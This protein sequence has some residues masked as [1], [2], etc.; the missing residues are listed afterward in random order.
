MGIVLISSQLRMA[1]DNKMTAGSAELSC[2]LRLKIKVWSPYSMSLVLGP[3]WRLSEERSIDTYLSKH[4]YIYADTKIH[5]HVN[6]YGCN[7]LY[8]MLISFSSVNFDTMHD[9]WLKL[10]SIREAREYGTWLKQN[11]S[12]EISSCMGSIQMWKQTEESLKI[13]MTNGQMY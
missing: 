9:I 13:T 3:Y 1:L 2:F 6:V 10:W 11:P 8:K 7:T 12:V 4:I 5:T